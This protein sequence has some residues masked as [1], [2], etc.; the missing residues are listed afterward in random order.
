VSVEVSRN[1]RSAQQNDRRI[2]FRK[3]VSELVI[4]LVT[5]SL[6]STAN[7]T[8]IV[9]KSATRG[10]IGFRGAGHLE[11][12]SSPAC[13]SCWLAPP[14]FIRLMTGST[15]PG[16]GDLRDPLRRIGR[17][18]Q[19]PFPPRGAQKPGSRVGTAHKIHN[20]TQPGN[21]VPR[22]QRNLRS[23]WLTKLSTR[24]YAQPLTES[25][26]RFGRRES[27]EFTFEAGHSIQVGNTTPKF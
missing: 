4:G 13:G 1:Y 12:F 15:R 25:T 6:T 26:A 24:L 11:P 21:R 8:L 9:G 7:D 20:E 14:N 5:D 2:C 10:R 19:C 22:S 18:L 3:E 16:L 27:A 23:K 17:F